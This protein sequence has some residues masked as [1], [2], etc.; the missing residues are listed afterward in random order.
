MPPD[1]PFYKKVV[2]NHEEHSFDNNE[3]CV[4]EYEFSYV[5]VLSSPDK[6]NSPAVDGVDDDTNTDYEIPM[7]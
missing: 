6:H 7:K 2:V 4:V 1:S 3:K 5:H